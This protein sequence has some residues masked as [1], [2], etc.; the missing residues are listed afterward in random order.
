MRELRRRGVL[1]I[2][3]S[4]RTARGVEPNLRAFADETLYLQ[5]PKFKSLWRAAWTLLRDRKRID[6]LL[7]RIV[8]YGPESPARR[9]RA[10]LH[11]LLGAYFS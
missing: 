1:V 3:C 6:D 2:P 7:P 8:K 5:R 11:T 4:A 9:I 10:L